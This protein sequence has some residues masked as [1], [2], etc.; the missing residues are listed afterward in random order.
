MLLIDDILTFPLRGLMWV[1]EEILNAAEQEKGEEA[2]AITRDLQKLYQA[3]E[4][5]QMTEEEFNKKEGELLDR[6]D[7][8]GIED[9]LV[10]RS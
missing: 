9:S 1:A 2:E 6:L 5:G 3:L 8:L 10:R 7:A 4:N